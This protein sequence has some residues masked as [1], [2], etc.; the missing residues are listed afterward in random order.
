MQTKTFILYAIN[1]LTPLLFVFF[2]IKK[3]F[4]GQSVV[5][6]ISCQLIDADFQEAQ[7][8]KVRIIEGVP[9]ARW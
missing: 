4:F 2:T 7:A 8:Y 3:I 6:A 9:V 5:H 1:R